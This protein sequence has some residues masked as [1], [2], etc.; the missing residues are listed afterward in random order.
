[1]CK[2]QTTSRQGDEMKIGA[3]KTIGATMFAA[4]EAAV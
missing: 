4:G 3:G 2:S 1:M